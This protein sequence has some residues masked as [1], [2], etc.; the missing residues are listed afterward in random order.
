MKKFLTIL[1]SL[2]VASFA[3]VGI[4]RSTTGIHVPSAETMDRGMLY[5]SGSYEMVTDSKSMSM[6]G[7][8]IDQ[9]GH[10][11]EIDENTASNDESVFFSFSI[12]DNLELNF[13]LP[14]H[15]DS[16]VEGATSRSFGLGDFQI[17]A[18]G[19]FPVSDTWIF[20]A[21]SEI[22]IPAGFK[23]TGFRPRHRWF[24]NANG[25]AYAYT[26]GNIGISAYAHATA[27]FGSTSSV[28]AYMGVVKIFDSSESHALWGVGLTILPEKILSVIL[29]ISGETPI[30]SSNL[31]Y[32]FLS[33][34][35][36]FTP[37]LRMHLPSHFDITLS[38]DV[39]V[40]YFRGQDNQ[41]GLP[42]N[43]KT[44]KAP[45]RY[46]ALGSP[47]LGI[48][49]TVSK[50]VNL[51]WL[52]SD[53]DG[54]IDRE[55]MCP[56]T[57]NGMSVNSR[58]C[59][60]D[61]D[62][63]GVLNIVDL[64][65]GTLLGLEVDYNGCPID[66]DKDGVFDYQDKCLGTPA[67][68]AVDAKGCTLD[69]DNDGVDDNN[70][71]CPTSIPGEPVDETGCPLD[72]DHDGVKNDLDKCPGSPEGVSID[73]D[74]CPLDFDKDGVPDDLDKCPNTV[75]GELVNEIGCPL[76]TDGDG[77]P[78]SKDKCP[79]TIEGALVDEVGCRV[80]KDEDGVF[81]DNDKC[82]N[83]PKGAPI[84]SLGCP[85]DSDGDGVADWYDQCP[86]SFKNVVVDSKGCPMNDRLNFSAI[87]KRIKFKSDTT[88]VNSSYT[89]MNDIVANMRQ[90]PI[91]L[92]IQC[93]APQ[94]SLADNRAKAIYNYL[95]HK[96]ISEER[97]KYEGFEKKLPKTISNRGDEANGIRLT[98][99]TL[100]E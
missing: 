83:T 6:E 59:P 98:P 46:N 57:R 62:A 10:E 75:E 72:E 51:S 44:G 61:E 90:Y 21:S 7:F 66:A 39:G 79:E 12:L 64:C 33:S 97:L 76:D 34:P 88:F 63:D 42:V 50:R 78:D 45:I 77:V 30:H 70:D 20:G 17:G 68:F 16:Q 65:P 56:N 15:Y 36:R 38:G 5:V 14:F 48:G 27:N 29:E 18:K 89:A 67:G 11:V 94:K 1:S 95:E 32:N 54:V 31:A 69:S 9:N 37:G 2:A 28:S 47:N 86:A 22:I 71:K 55:D 40:N 3:Q 8:Y 87:A 74:G 41:D 35:F 100:Q 92:E 73:T 23:G 19:S 53:G 58:G 84:D 80:D 93:A 26:S 99:F 52:D 96:G 60:V 49:I 43:L 82:P 81:D 91:A 85:L 4:G 25:D 24:I 13:R